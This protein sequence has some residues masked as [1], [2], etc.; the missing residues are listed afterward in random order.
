M[1]VVYS[2]HLK[3]HRL[4]RG[5][6][7][8]VRMRKRSRIRIRI[9]VYKYENRN[10]TNLNLENTAVV[11]HMFVSRNERRYNFLK[12]TQRSV[13]LCTHCDSPFLEAGLWD[14]CPIYLKAT[15]CVGCEKLNDYYLWQFSRHRY[16]QY[17]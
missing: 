10:C 9:S 7:R 8:G 3:R 4:S 13:S 15:K 1:A 11:R 17:H 16:H 2:S 14:F 5:G 12:F 6:G